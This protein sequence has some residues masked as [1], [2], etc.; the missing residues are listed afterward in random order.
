[1]ASATNYEQTERLCTS[2]RL[3][4]VSLRRLERL[5]APVAVLTRTLEQASGV[6]ARTKQRV[7]LNGSSTLNWQFSL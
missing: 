4:G 3:V 7:P 5:L 6:K 1:M 2:R